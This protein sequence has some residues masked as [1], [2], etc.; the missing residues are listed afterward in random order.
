MRLAFR[1]KYTA[2]ARSF[3]AS[4][5]DGVWMDRRAVTN[6]LT[7]QAGRR[8]VL[9]RHISGDAGG[10]R[11]HRDK[12]EAGAPQGHAE[13]VTEILDE[14]AHERSEGNCD[15]NAAGRL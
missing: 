1:R 3:S 8:T 14:G 9:A 15:A 2:S 11:Q 10:Q 7:L 4:S 5:A 13:T 6:F 12:S